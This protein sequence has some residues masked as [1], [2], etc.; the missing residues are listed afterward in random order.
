L[1]E[2][3][4][5]FSLA[6]RAALVTG[7]SRGIGESMADGLAGAGARV[8]R[9]GHVP[10]PPE[11]AEADYLQADLGAPEAPAAL[12]AAAFE[13][14]P[15]LDI[16]VSN[17]GGFFD[18]PFLEMT[19]ERWERTMR[20]NLRA[21]YF[22]IQ[23]FARRLVA[24]NRRGAVVVTASTNGLQAEDQSSAYDISKGGLVML[25]RTLA[26]ELA[27]HGIRVNAVAPGLIRTPLTAPW[28]DA[29]AALRQHYERSIPQGRIGAADDCA[30]AAVYLASDAA[31]YV[32]GHIL[33]V[34]GGLTIRQIGPLPD[35]AEAE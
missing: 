8:L 25:T 1:T 30:G 10:R 26:L 18:V 19:H 29:N 11:I 6:G 21:A 5:A 9:H 13:R 34:D 23:A 16:L 4:D 7:S 15:H 17:A 28:M 35:D 32:T 14:C 24:E 3:T 22:L 20:L 2:I 31:A 33:V 27:P 12:I